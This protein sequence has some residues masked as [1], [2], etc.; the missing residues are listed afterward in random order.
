MM[1]SMKMHANE[2]DINQE[3]V[4]SLI[5]IQFPEYVDLSLEAVQSSGT[6]NALYKLGDELVVRLPR[7]AAKEPPIEKEYKWLPLLAPRLPLAVPTP[8]AVG[9]P[10]E[11]YPFKWA[12]YHWLEGKPAADSPPT[13]LNQAAK[14]LADFICALQDIDTTGAP[15]PHGDYDRGVPLIRRDQHTRS[16]IAALK[17][18]YD[19]DALT[20]GWKR[21]LEE[22]VWHKKP[23]WI[24][25][26]LDGRNMLVKDGNLSAVIDFGSIGVGDPAYDAMVAW[27]VFSGE[28]REVFKDR[29]KIDEPTWIRGRGLVLSQAVMILSYYTNETNPV[30]VREA[31]NWMGQLGF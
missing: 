30:L 17:D 31:Q 11:S 21:A 9:K 8:V 3:I 12:I 10:N 29:L 20:L 19:I 14:V 16:A 26:D 4:E 7:T 22:A 6:D 25:G 23:V 2:V 13:D 27:K 18:T 28:S 1:I 24:H 15:I 5:S